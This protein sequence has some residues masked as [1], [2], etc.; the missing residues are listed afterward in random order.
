MVVLEG[1]GLANDATALVLYRFAV[2]AV[3]VGAFSFDASR[4]ELGR[5][6]RR[7]DHLGNWRRLADASPQAL[8]PRSQSR[9]H[10]LDPDAIR[11]LLA[12]R[13][14][15]RLGRARDRSGRA[16]H[17]LERPSVDQRRDPASGR[18]LL[19]LPRLPD[20]RHGVPHHRTAERARSSRASPPTRFR[21]LAMA[22]AVVSAVVILARFVWVYPAAYLP[23]WLVPAIRRRDPTPSWQFL[24]VLGFTGIRGVVSLAA[25]LAI[26]YIDSRRKPLSGP[27]PDPVSDLLRDLRDPGRRRLDAALG[28]ARPWSRACRTTRAARRE[29]RGVPGAETCARGGDP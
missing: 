4:R 1:E 23:R 7:R 17:Q 15:R 11:R 21:E 12:A 9:D 13:A 22:A 2:V 6:S 20:R 10:A 27:R 18:L 29:K 24:F 19:G 28:H 14:A 25:A 8:G 16:L 3:S 26:P 5:N